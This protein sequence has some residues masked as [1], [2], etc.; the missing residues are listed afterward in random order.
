M[1]SGLLEL[2]G[3]VPGGALVDAALAAG[4]AAVPDTP[5][6]WRRW[7]KCSRKLIAA[8]SFTALNDGLLGHGQEVLGRWAGLMVRSRG[9]PGQI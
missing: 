8:N 9:H 2:A 4:S 3:L 1:W 6:S 5:R 7:T